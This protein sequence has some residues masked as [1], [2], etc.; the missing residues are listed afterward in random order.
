MAMPM[1]TAPY[2]NAVGPEQQSGV[3][4]MV[5]PDQGVQNLQPMQP[6]SPVMFVLLPGYPTYPPNFG[7]YPQA[8]PV[9]P[10]AGPGFVPQ[11]PFNMGG[12]GVPMA[13]GSPMQ[14]N[15][16]GPS[17]AGVGM[18]RGAAPVND[19]IPTPWFGDDLDAAQP[20]ALFSSSRSS[21]PIQLNLLQEELTKPLEPQNTTGPESLHEHHAKA[22]RQEC[23]VTSSFRGYR[24]HYIYMCL[25]HHIYVHLTIYN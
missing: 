17:A 16:A 10:V 5:Q 4:M 1:Q 21:S 2:F 6:V 13:Q 3:P 24:C 14:G 18:P 7:M 25:K 15:L 12:Y 22:V 8:M 11:P 20:T 23:W 9:A 19:S